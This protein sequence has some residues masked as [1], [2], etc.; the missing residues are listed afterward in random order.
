MSCTVAVATRVACPRKWFPHPKIISNSVDDT[1]VGLAQ[2]VQVSRVAL[3]NAPGVVFRRHDLPR[4][5]DPPPLPSF[6]LHS[7]IAVS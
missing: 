4:Q 6:F 7:G 1:T 5:T 3:D 2:G